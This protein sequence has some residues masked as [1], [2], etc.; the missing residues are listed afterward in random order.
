MRRRGSTR[1]GQTAVRAAVASREPGTTARCRPARHRSRPASAGSS[2]PSRHARVRSATLRRGQEQESDAAVNR[3]NSRDGS[4]CRRS[5]RRRT[6]RRAP[7]QR[8]AAV[9]GCEPG[10][11]HQAEAPA[12]ARQRDRALD[13]QLIAVRVP[14]RLRLVDAGVAR[15]AQDRKHVGAWLS[16]R[17]RYRRRR[18]ES[19]PMADFRSQRRNRRA[20][21]RP[22][23]IEEHLRKLELP[24][25]EAAAAAGFL[26]RIEISAGRLRR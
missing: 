10:G 3:E 14:V 7:A 1:S 6:G 9:I 18:R 25:K 20:A 16:A 24:V 26:G 15:E 4:P 23:A 13:E 8:R 2:T 5:R 17:D 19:C 11:Q 22:V 12:G 21:R